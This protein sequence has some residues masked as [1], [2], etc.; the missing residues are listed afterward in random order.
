MDEHS[1]INLH[2]L[3]QAFQEFD[4]VSR[5]LSQNYVRLGATVE[6]LTDRMVDMTAGNS[7]GSPSYTQAPVK[8]HMIMQV[9]PVAIIIVDAGGV[10]QYAN[11]MAGELFGVSLLGSLW[12]DTIASGIFQV[13][14]SGEMIL[15]DGRVI[16]ATTSPIG[17]EPGQIIL[18]QD[19][20]NTSNLRSM[21]DIY[22][23]HSL[24]YQ[25]NAAIAH[26]VRTPLTSALL[27]LAQLKSEVISEKGLTYIERIHASLD[28]LDSLA[29]NA[30]ETVSGRQKKRTRVIIKDVISEVK[31]ML[32]PLMVSAGCELITT[33]HCD[34]VELDC[35]SELLKS[36]IINLVMNSAQACIEKDGLSSGGNDGSEGSPFINITAEKIMMGIG[37]C[38]VKI[39]VEDNGIGIEKKKLV[40]VVRPFFT[41]KVNGTGLG[42]T[43]AKS[44]I[45]GMRGSLDIASKRLKGTCVTLVIPV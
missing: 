34:G 37:K 2:S 18:F 21:A 30:L 6:A 31:A 1:A 29:T 35:D 27:Y 24:A 8:L 11:N 43:V 14:D 45:E 9:L 13:T 22:N 25:V 10:V 38:V 4:R 15:T 26:Q 40:D 39:K 28:H 20:T 33:V 23:R 12:R 17:F 36:I 7:C 5:T 44:V 42:L 19:V 16:L 32:T 3:E 41:T